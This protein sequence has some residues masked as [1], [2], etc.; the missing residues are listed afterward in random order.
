MV[1]HDPMEAKVDRFA[2]VADAA[3]FVAE[4][5]ENAEGR[6]LPGEEGGYTVFTIEF[7][8]GCRYFGYTQGS[9]FECVSDL[10]C[11]PVEVSQNK[12]V[13]EHVGHMAYVVRCVASNLGVGNARELVD[14]LVCGAPGEVERG[15]GMT[16]EVRDCPLGE[17][18]PVVV[19]MSFGDWVQSQGSVAERGNSE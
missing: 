6:R 5:W 12:F 4:W 14:L 17:H 15:Y 3:A 13:V 2:D 11:G 10:G 16:I 8:D 19:S 18:A 1:M 7:W 9:V